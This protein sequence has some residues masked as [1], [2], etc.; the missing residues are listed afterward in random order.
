MTSTHASYCTHLY[1]MRHGATLL[2]RTCRRLCV[3]TACALTGSSAAAPARSPSESEVDER[4]PC[5][6]A[7]RAS[8][9]N[10]S[11]KR[12]P[13][14][15]G[16]AHLAVLVRLATAAHDAVAARAC[17]GRLRAR[18]GSDTVGRRAACTHSAAETASANRQVVE[19]WCAGALAHLA[20]LHRPGPPRAAGM[21]FAPRI[22]A[23]LTSCTPRAPSSVDCCLLCLCSRNCCTSSSI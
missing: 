13:W 16:W 9:V 3:P 6:H 22:P 18:P 12:E 15:C 21:A 2:Y 11:Q 4:S 23:G 19:R 14:R 17:S 1:L 20:V 10:P 7:C 5:G 8:T